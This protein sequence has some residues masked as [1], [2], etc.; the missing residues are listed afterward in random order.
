MLKIMC[1][2]TDSI[3]LNQL[4]PFQ[5][6]LKKR[7]SKDIKQLTD[8]LLTEGLLMPFAVW[9]HDGINSLL[10][11]HGRYAALVDMSLIDNSILEQPLPVVYIDA[12][13]E[14]QARKSL[15]QITSSYGKITRDGVMAFTKTIPN[16]TAPS[17]R[18]FTHSFKRRKPV[19][20]D[21]E[22]II[23]IAVP[24]DKAQAVLELFKSVNYIRV[25]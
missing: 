11:G 3:L 21:M 6:T 22:Q 19:K 4:T 10:D 8:S 20:N 24:T 15:L 18:K 13:T 23:K 7:T 5:E 9:R 14:E 2:T 1:Q 16:Y 17:I 12:D 25:L